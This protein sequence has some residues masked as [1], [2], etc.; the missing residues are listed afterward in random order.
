MLHH[1]DAGLWLALRVRDVTWLGFTPHGSHK[2]L[3][4]FTSDGSWAMVNDIAQQVEQY[5][6][7]NLW[8]E[9]ETVHDRW[10]K[11]GAPPRDR[12]GLTVTDTGT[13]QFWLDNPDTVVWVD[14]G[15]R[16]S[17]IHFCR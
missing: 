11:A 3:W 16:R 4:L 6:P 2:Q 14:T 17:D 8:D 12:L 15:A 5:G 1:R 10:H 7:R 13:H 9:I